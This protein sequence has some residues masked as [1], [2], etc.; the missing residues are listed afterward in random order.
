M[1]NDINNVLRGKKKA[2]GGDGGGGGGGGVGIT[3][4]IL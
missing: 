2:N 4:K 1:Q 3:R